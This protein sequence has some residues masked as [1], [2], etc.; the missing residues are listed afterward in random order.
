MIAA[1][2]RRSL[3]KGVTAAGL[4]SS[5]F[6]SGCIEAYRDMPVILDDGR[7]DLYSSI[8]LTYTEGKPTALVTAGFNRLGK[9]EAVRL[10]RGGQIAVNGVVLEH[11][12]RDYDYNYSADIPAPGVEIKVEF[13]RS[14]AAPPAVA[15][16]RMP[17]FRVLSRP[18]VYK[19]HDPVEITWVWDPDPTSYRPDDAGSR[20]GR[21]AEVERGGYSLV[22][23]GVDQPRQRF[24]PLVPVDLPSASDYLLRIFMT[25]AYAIDS[26]L[27]FKLGNITLAYG[28]QFPIEVQK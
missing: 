7:M 18:K 2:N 11:R 9:R 6:L 25:R 27:P 10:V 28:Q 22:P 24:V 3:L 1:N 12:S 21:R 5:P 15:T 4:L 19:L 16:V 26:L 17:R 14:D 20:I 8:A 13:W 23:D